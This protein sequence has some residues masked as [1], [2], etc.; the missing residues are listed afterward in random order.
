MCSLRI[1]PSI[2]LALSLLL[3]WPV[4]GQEGLGF[5]VGKWTP[6]TGP[7]IGAPFWFHKAALGYDAVIPWWGQT[8]IIASDGAYGSHI[9]VAGITNG[10]SIE[11]YYYLIILNPLKMSW[12]LRYGGSKLCPGSLVFEREPIE[13][14]IDKAF[15]D[16]A[17]LANESK[18]R[19]V[20][21]K[22]AYW[23]DRGIWQNPETFCD[24]MTAFVER[25]TNAASFKFKDSGKPVDLQKFASGK[26]EGNFFIRS[27]SATPE[28]YCAVT[29][30]GSDYR[31]SCARRITESPL[32]YDR[33]F[34]RTI[35]DLRTC[36]KQRGWQA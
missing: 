1:F 33:V 6:T 18:D 26:I 29:D 4:R 3:N 9:K 8:T 7:N 20:W 23:K 30:F 32:I 22:W 17:V 28:S 16:E 25:G 35:N 12:N 5:L 24:S 11:C 19:P 10:A 31:V 15:S 13:P 34:Q 14:P 27:D 21:Q 2:V 36:A